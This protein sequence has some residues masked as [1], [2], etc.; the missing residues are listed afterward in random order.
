MPF[1]FSNGQWSS[2]QIPEG[3]AAAVA[4]GAA[5]A[6][7]VHEPGTQ[8]LSFPSPQSSPQADPVPSR[9]QVRTPHSPHCCV[10]ES[11]ISQRL[12]WEFSS[13]RQNSKARPP[14][15]AATK[16]RPPSPQPAA[17]SKPPPIQK[18]ALTPP[19]P[20]TLRKRDSKSKDMMPIQALSLQAADSSKSKDK[21]K[22]KD[23]D[24]E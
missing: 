8:P 17:A 13:F 24:G 5:S 21:D 19:G 1:C 15:P 22:D 20:T 10:T 2:L 11:F 6:L 7:P 4:P 14:S 16:Q 18:Q 9:Y 3:Q 23:K 12:K